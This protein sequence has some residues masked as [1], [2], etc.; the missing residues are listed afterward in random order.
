M[1]LI[2]VLIGATLVG[3]D[4]VK[5]TATR[6]KESA[7]DTAIELK[8]EDYRTTYKNYQPIKNFCK[9]FK[10]GIA[11]AEAEREQRILQ[12]KLQSIK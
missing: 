5:N 1:K 8:N 9:D 7:I 2:K 10:A 6:I 4:N 12:K 11:K 3:C